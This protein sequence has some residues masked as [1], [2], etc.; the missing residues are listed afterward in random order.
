MEVARIHA[1]LAETQGRTYRSAI[2]EHCRWRDWAAYKDG[3]PQIPANELIGYLNNTVFPQF[4][5][6]HFGGRFGG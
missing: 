2:P 5:V 4:E 6:L 1:E 3:R